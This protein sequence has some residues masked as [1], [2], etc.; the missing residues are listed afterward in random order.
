MHKNF[1]PAAKRFFEILPGALTWSA[2]LLPA[3]LA[4]WYPIPVAIFVICFDLYWLYRSVELSNN[5]IRVYNRMR[6]AAKTNW[7]QKLASLGNTITPCGYKLDEVYQ[8]IIIVAYK[9]PAELL[10]ASINSYV[11]SNFDVKKRTIL[12]LGTEERAG[13]HS[14]HLNQ[15]LS[16]RFKDKFL[17][18]EHTIHPK[19]IPGEIKCKSANATW[20]AKH[21]Y[22]ICEEM[23]ISP[24][25]VLLHNFDADTR[26][27]KEYFAY[28]QWN[29]M[30]TPPDQHTCYQ[31]IHI[32]NNNIWDTG[33]PMRVI[34]ISST[35]IFMHNTMRPTHFYNFSS[36]SDCFQ[37]VVDI[38][39]WTVN[40]I[41][42]DS[43]EYYDAYFRYNGKLT[44][45]P[46]YIPLY[47]DA[48][49]SE[50]YWGSLMNQYRQ[51]R[52]WAWGVIDLAYLAEKSWKDTKIPWTSKL[53]RILEHT[54]SNFSRSTT[55]LFLGFFGW[56]PLIVN[57]RF[58]DTM[59]GYHMLSVTQIILTLAI[60]GTLT[61]LYLS[62]LLLP[63]RPPHHK[64]IKYIGFL[65]QWV[66]VPFVSIFLG[67]F[68]AIDAQTRLMFGKYLEY[69]VTEKAV[70]Q[71]TKAELG[72][73]S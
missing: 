66:L 51:L 35:F 28:V 14:D 40:A 24:K 2:L 21:L 55:A 9:E 33:A 70:G 46:Q 22:K 68:S 12:V 5:I 27:H 67:S 73:K 58:H 19:N 48:V 34:A 3:L 62:Y 45:Q 42:E 56:I 44:I 47:M 37:T 25:Q 18:F 31:P 61:S 13:E 1:P 23:R 16:E 54:E 39:Y 60:V 4:I 72:A 17:R 15:Y 64:P 11:N 41:P 63:P 43:R 65:L 8:A 26:T 6:S 69:Q 59:I 52:R 57:N 36:R 50:G 20:A 10:E 38:G 7:H 53:G 49:L 32:Y 29:F 71:S 30:H